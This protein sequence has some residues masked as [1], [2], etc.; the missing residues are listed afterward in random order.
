VCGESACVQQRRERVAH[1][2]YVNYVMHRVTHHIA[3]ARRRRAR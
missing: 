1:R 2:E 3:R